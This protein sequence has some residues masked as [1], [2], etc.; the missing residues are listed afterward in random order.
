[1][2]DI[3]D[4]YVCGTADAPLLGD[5]IGRS[6]DLAVQRWGNREALVSPSHGVRWS[7]KEFSDRVEALAAGLLALGLTPGDARFWWLLGIDQAFHHATDFA[8][9]VVLTVNA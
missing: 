9:A 2:T 4:S 5:T 3:A 1:M 7:W 8:L 6:L